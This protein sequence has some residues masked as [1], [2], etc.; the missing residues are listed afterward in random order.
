MKRLLRRVVDEEGRDWDL[1]LPYVLFAVREVPQASTGFSPFKPVY[2][3]RPRGLLDLARET[4][5]QHS[6]PFLTTIDHVRV[7]EYRMQRVLLLVREHMEQAQMAQR[8][9][10]NRQARL[11]VFAPG[12]KVMVPDARSKF[13]AAWRGPYIIAESLSSVHYRV[14]QEGRRRENQVYHVNLLKEGE[15]EGHPV[16][17]A[18]IT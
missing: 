4:W 15:G 17:S 13:L 2:G 16:L 7:M 3:R 8:R 1:M 18:A 10:Y 9:A 11:C 14:R 12:D 6:S 5:E